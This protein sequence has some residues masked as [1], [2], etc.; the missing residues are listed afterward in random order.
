M[1][2]LKYLNEETPTKLPKYLWHGTKHFELIFGNN[3]VMKANLSNDSA[4][5][6][7][8]DPSN[9]IEYNFKFWFRINTSK[10]SPND[11]EHATEWIYSHEDEYMYKKDKFDLK[12][13]TDLLMINDVIHGDMDF[14]YPQTKKFIDKYK[15]KI[16]TYTGKRF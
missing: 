8:T 2:L 7:T 1:N 11:F 3:G 16:K 13:Y 6:F 14:L 5:R 15:I 12:K 10:L 9:L 4:I